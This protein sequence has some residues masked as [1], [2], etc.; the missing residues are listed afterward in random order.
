M[1]RDDAFLLDILESARIALRHLGK[2]SIDD[3]QNDVLCQDAVIRRLE[4]IGEATRRTSDETR[5]TY[6]NL[7]W[8]DMVKMRN[9]MIHKYDDIDMSLVYETVLNDLPPLIAVLED[10]FK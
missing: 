8:S 10:V 1:L 5:G 2:K 4:I 7:P 9:V 3:F 6:P